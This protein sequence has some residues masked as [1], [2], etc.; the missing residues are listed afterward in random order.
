MTY[1]QNPSCG[2]CEYIYWITKT[3]GKG[4]DVVTSYVGVECQI[5]P[6]NP[7]PLPDARICIGHKFHPID[8]DKIP[9]EFAKKVA[10]ILARE[11]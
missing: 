5:D 4:D 3:S 1:P 11:E 6:F 2:N 8:P 9:V 10:V 7:R